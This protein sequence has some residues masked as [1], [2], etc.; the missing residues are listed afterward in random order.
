[1]RKI[2][3]AAAAL[4][5]II[6]SIAQA[7]PKLIVKK[8]VTEAGRAA[9][10]ARSATERGSERPWKIKQPSRRNFWQS[11]SFRTRG[12]TL[13][14]PEYSTGSMAAR[15]DFP[16]RDPGV[17]VFAT[18]YNINLFSNHKLRKFFEEEQLAGSHL[19]ARY[20]KNFE[21][22]RKEWP[23]LESFL[24]S[25]VREESTPTKADSVD[26]KAIAR[27][28]ERGL[29]AALHKYIA[30]ISRFI[31]KAMSVIVGVYLVYKYGLDVL[32]LLTALVYMVGHELRI[33]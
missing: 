7:G 28:V 32:G 23:F 30:E 17:Y 22:K 3:L 5:C 1:L 21:L 9:L 13:K 15:R 16:G 4:L 25:D 26:E 2:V 24:S 19:T 14:A 31:Y 18:M 8:W 12:P 33:W 27:A 29:D 20:L 6:P 10:G 11:A